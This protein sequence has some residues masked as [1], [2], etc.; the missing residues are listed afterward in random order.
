MT[1]ST[2]PLVPSRWQATA[3]GDDPLDP[4]NL[5]LAHCGCNTSESNRLR[6]MALALR[7]CRRQVSAGRLGKRTVQAVRPVF[8]SL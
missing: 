5:A 2:L 3:Q 1:E 4:A 7:R 6:G 8:D